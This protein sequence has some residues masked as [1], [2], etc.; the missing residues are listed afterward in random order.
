MVI[1]ANIILVELLILLSSKKLLNIPKIH[2]AITAERTGIYW[3]LLV[4]HMINFI[5]PWRF[6]INGGVRNFVTKINLGV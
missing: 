2:K 1:T 6:S 3:G 4:S 5:L